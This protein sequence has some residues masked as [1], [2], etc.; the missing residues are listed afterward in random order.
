MDEPILFKSPDEA[1]ISGSFLFKRLR[2]CPR[3]QL[4]AIQFPPSC[5]TTVNLRYTTLEISMLYVTQ[6]SAAVSCPLYFVLFHPSLLPNPVVPSLSLMGC[7][8][9]NRVARYLL[10]KRSTSRSWS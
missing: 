6:T 9:P 8:V 4:I 7:A 3:E 1:Q 5:T 10:K 2:A